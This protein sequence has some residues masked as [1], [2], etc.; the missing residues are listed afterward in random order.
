MKMRIFVTALMLAVVL[1]SS[2]FA[3][4][5]A[6]TSLGATA[7]SYCGTGGA[8]SPCNLGSDV[9]NY[10]ID[11][12][13]TTQWIANGAV[14]NPYV[15]IN[16]GAVYN[17]DFVSVSGVGNTG[18]TISFELFGGLTST[19]VTVLGTETLQ[20]GGTAWTDTFTLPTP[21]NYQYV[22]YYVTGGTDWGYATTIDVDA[23]PEPGTIGL[24]GSGLLALGFTL[25]R[26][27]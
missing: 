20:A 21:A 5:V 12:N 10:A 16:L 24:I 27:K 2:A 25:R 1:A 9:A 22:E 19:P 8:T 17:V 26:K 3:G 11:N 6:L 7:Q 15:L 14:V 18:N 23:T 13:S 4:N